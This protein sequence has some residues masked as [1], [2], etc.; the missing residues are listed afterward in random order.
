MSYQFVEK[1]V[2]VNGYKI[3]YL[4]GGITLNSEPI[5]F[6]HG[7]GVSIEPYQELIDVLCQRYKVIAPALPGFGRS[8]GDRIDWDYDK[9]ADF[10]LAFLQKLDIKKAHLIGH[11]LGGGI[12]ITLAARVPDIVSSLILV[13]STGI[14]VAPI[15]KVLFQR[16]IEMTAQTPQIQFPQ[17]QQIFKGFSYNLLF[18]TQNTIQILLLTLKKDIKSLLPQIQSPCLVVW[19]ANDLTTPLNAGQEFHQGIKNS[20]LIVVEKGYHEWSIFFVD[21]ITKIIFNFLEERVID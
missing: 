17:L 19:G 2:Y 7:W 4:E 11:S 15:P 10:L 3:S 6:I 9:Y 13:D 20:K 16:I 18:H 5:L 8:D 21:K 14:P 12:N 1:Q